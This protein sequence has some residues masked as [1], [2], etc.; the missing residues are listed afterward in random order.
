MRLL[1]TLLAAAAA[2]SVSCS[3]GTG[4]ASDTPSRA[5]PGGPE[6]AAARLA[7]H[8]RA[9]ERIANRNGGTRATGT[10]G[11]AVSVANVLDELREAGYEP[12]VD[13]FRYPGYV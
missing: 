8:L 9:L 13:R 10:P 12:S 3:G 2:V 7:G 1:A 11:Y 5:H 6:I 4:D